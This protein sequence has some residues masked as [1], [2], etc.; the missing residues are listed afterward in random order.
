MIR[1]FTLPL[2]L[3]AAAAYADDIDD[4]RSGV[5]IDFDLKSCNY[6]YSGV[7]TG[8]GSVTDPEAPATRAVKPAGTL[9]MNLN[10]GSLFPGVN[11]DI[12]LTGTKLS[13]TQVRWATDVA[14]NVTVTVNV[15]GVPTSLK[16]TRI[17]GQ[18]TGN[19][20]LV[21]LF[22]DSVC[23]QGYNVRLDDT[24]SN[25]DTWL[26]VNSQVNG[27]PLLP[28]NLQLRDIDF[29]DFSGV[30]RG[31]L[32]ADSFSVVQGLHFG[33][34]LAS[35]RTSDNDKIV[36]LCDELSP[37]GEVVYEGTSAA[38]APGSITMRIESSS[39]RTDISQLLDAYNFGA[40]AWSQQDFFVP[41]LSDTVRTKVLTAPAGT[42]VQT[43]TRAM[44]SRVRWIPQQD[45]DA[46]DGWT[47]S[48]DQLNWISAP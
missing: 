28:I 41:L 16:I 27:I 44:R 19:S 45:I 24:A 47:Y 15:G 31:D 22:Y 40:S 2:V 29:I 43:G 9:N 23:Q 25:A 38:P 14:P 35:A 4:V 48:A 34:S 32:F 39:S 20:A 17:W 33:G 8:A 7:Q 12:P 36:V 5:D 3:L 37:N 18:I 46:G 26:N 21:P 30:P 6:T 11:I 1:W 42:F 10:A 13:P